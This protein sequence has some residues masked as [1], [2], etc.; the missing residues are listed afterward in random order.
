[1]NGYHL[2]LSLDDECAR[3]AVFDP[4]YRAVLDKLKYGNEGERQK[5]RA[6]LPQ[7]T[8][9]YIKI[10][11]K[12]IER[13]L[14][15]SGYLAFWLDKFSI[16]SGHHLRYF[17]YC[18][19]MQFV[20][21]MCWETRRFGMGRRLRSGTEYLLIVQ[22]KPTNAKNTWSDHS[23]RDYWEE[24]VSRLSHPHRK[25]IELTKRIILAV[26]KPGDLVVDPCAGSYVVL[27]ACKATK[28]DFIGCD[29]I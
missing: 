3:L 26:T 18:T 19:C 22:K 6:E 13:V 5:K 2:L 27:D 17:D 28:R 23:M 4:Q 14:K 11:V 9:V 1:M 15:P 29:L 16:A 10:F 20:D 7:M 24:A 21:L 12:Q 25:P 8:D